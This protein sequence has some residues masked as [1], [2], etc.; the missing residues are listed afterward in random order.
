MQESSSCAVDRVE[1]NHFQESNFNNIIRSELLGQATLSPARELSVETETE[2]TVS[3]KFSLV[4]A[5][6]TPKLM[7][8]KNIFCSRNLLRHEQ[9]MFSNLEEHQEAPSHHQIPFIRHFFLLV[10]LVVNLLKA[11]RKLLEKFRKFRLKFS[12]PRH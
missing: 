11:H 7:N 9:K 6:N 8:R 12:M 1:N 4:F 2:R 10:H 5:F 3:R